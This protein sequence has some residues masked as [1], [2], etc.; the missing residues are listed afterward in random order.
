MSKSTRKKTKQLP[1]G[2]TDRHREMIEEIMGEISYLPSLTSVVQQAVVDMHDSVVVKK[3]GAQ[4]K[5]RI[6]FKKK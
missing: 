4:Y 2:F 6:T 3:G 1:I 5:D